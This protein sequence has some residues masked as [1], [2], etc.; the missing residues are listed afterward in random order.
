MGSFNRPKYDS[1]GRHLG[2]HKIHE[3]ESVQACDCEN[4]KKYPNDGIDEHFTCFYCGHQRG[5]HPMP[6]S[7][8]AAIREIERARAMMEGK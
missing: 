7:T 8:M 2:N 3:G 6:N 1:F 4:G 5:G